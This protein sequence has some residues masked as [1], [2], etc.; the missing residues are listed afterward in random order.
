MSHVEQL[1]IDHFAGEL[2]ATER[3]RMRRHL[4]DC[5]QCREQYDR[6]AMLLRAAA[7]QEP[8]DAEMNAWQREIED[9]LEPA[10]QLPAPEPRRRWFS[11]ALPRLVPVAGVALLGV[12]ALVLLREPPPE[13]LPHVQ[14]R[15]APDGAVLTPPPEALVE[16]EVFAIRTAAAA[17]PTPR[18]LSA[19]DQVGLDEY[20][21]FRR[22]CSGDRIRHL[23]LFGLDSRLAVLDYYPRPSSPASITLQG[24]STT[25]RAVG[26]S[27]RLTK[28]HLR[29]PLWV[30]ALYSEEPLTRAAIQQHVAKLKAGGQGPAAIERV[31]FGTGVYPVVRRFTLVESQR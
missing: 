22:I 17:A 23:Y 25:P 16:L 11:W 18:R 2:Q 27:I 30:V 14:Y 6:A 12:F 24:C 3:Q 10:A 8:T 26:R 1:I 13:E 7:D 21:Q 20:L 5:E 4:R 19:G 28:R 29:G 15:G 31:P 9:V